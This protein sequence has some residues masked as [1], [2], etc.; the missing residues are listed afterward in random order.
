MHDEA[1]GVEEDRDAVVANALR[2]R[3]ERLR[4]DVDEV[5]EGG[6]EARAG[7][8]CVIRAELVAEDFE[9]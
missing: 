5:V 2:G 8:A 3:I 9:P 1:A 7:G 6:G 4:A